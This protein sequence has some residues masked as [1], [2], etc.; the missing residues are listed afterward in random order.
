MFGWLITLV[1]NPD[2]TGRPGDRPFMVVTNETIYLKLEAHDA[3]LGKIESKLDKMTG[4]FSFVVPLV[5]CLAGIVATT[6]YL[7]H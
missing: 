4:A 2:D 7:Q 3:R 1:P 6:Y 5:T